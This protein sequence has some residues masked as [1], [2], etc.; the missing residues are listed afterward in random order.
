LN[1]ILRVEDV[2]KLLG[3]SKRTI[4]EMTRSEAI[5]HRRLAGRRRCLFRADELELWLDGV[6]LEVVRLQQGGRVVRP[7]YSTRTP[8]PS[9]QRNR[10]PRTEGED[11]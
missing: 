3:C 11:S 4:H 8:R 1:D 9:A 6:P 5:P 2:A 10:Y 7:A